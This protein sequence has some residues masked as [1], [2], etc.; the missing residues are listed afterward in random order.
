[1]QSS[2]GLND[3]NLKQNKSL[4]RFLFTQLKKNYGKEQ[5]KKKKKDDLS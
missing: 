1:M 3:Q 5:E 2:E 4:E